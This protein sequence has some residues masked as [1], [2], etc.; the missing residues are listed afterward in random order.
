MKPWIRIALGVLTGYWVREGKTEQAEL[1]K[2]ALAAQAK[3]KDIDAEMQAAAAK[4]EAEGEP[5]IEEI[6]AARKAIQAR[7]GG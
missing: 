4:W 2:D 1:L 3:G 6:T 5:T 7:V